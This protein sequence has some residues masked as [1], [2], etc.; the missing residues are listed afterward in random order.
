MAKNTQQPE[1]SMVDQVRIRREKLAQLQQEGRI[2]SHR[3][4]LNLPAT[5]PRSRKTSSRW[6]KGSL[7]Q[8]PPDDEARHG[9][10]HVL[11]SAGRCF[12]RIQLYLKIDEMDEATFER[13]RK[14]D[15][16]DIVGVHGDVFRTQRGEISVRAHEVVLLAKA[17]LPLPDKFHGLTNLE[18]RYRQRYVD[19]IVNPDVKDTFVKRSLILRELRSFLDGRGFLEVDTPI[20]PLFQDQVDFD[21]FSK[22]DF[23][24]VKVKEC[25]AVKKSKKLL[26]FVLDDGTG[27]DR[28]ILSGI[29]EY[30]EPEE[31]VGKTCIAITNLPPRA[32][33]G[34][35]SCG[36]LISAVHHEN[37]E[38]KAPRQFVDEI[39]KTLGLSVNNTKG[40]MDVC[41]G[42]SLNDSYWVVPADFDGKYADYNLYENRF[43]EALSLVAY[44]GVGGSREAFSTSP[45]LT[46][47]GMLRKAWRFVEGDGIYLY[48]GGTEG[49][50][51]AGREP[52]SEYYACQIADKMGIGCVQYDLENWKGILASK[53][54]LFTDIDTSFVPIGRILRKTTLKACLDYYKTLGDEFYE[55]L[56]SMLVFDA[57][58]Y[59]EDRH[60]GNFGLL[61]NNHTGEIIAPAPIFDNGL[62]LFNYAMPDDFKN[63]SAYAKT[64]SN[65][66]RISYEDVCKEVMGA[67]Q[68]A[69]LR[70][71][72]DFKFTRHPSL[73]LPE[74]RLTAIEKQLGERTREL[75]SIPVQRSAKRT[76]E[77]ER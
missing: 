19:L 2:P 73:N 34:I 71:M 59:N 62:S 9:Q 63:L 35:D 18:T 51:N 58:I 16:G 60:F 7:R 45:E 76:N 70:R 39:L 65:P 33:M 22:S 77:P 10:G 3:Q 53:C 68:K 6:R 37:G 1:L 14:L 49:V 67:K 72:V 61:R 43:S 50:P 40:I 55:Q 47:N 75:L 52:Y 4:S 66:Y 64:R 29:H 20:Q 28:V 15:I 42:L 54:R 23:R 38:E 27:T 25:E 48:K 11:R 30:Y 56:C 5:A 32:M 44:T 13:C 17:L 74:E 46:T 26:K 31:L 21:T 69:Q 36:M 24:A 12:G 8:R 57:L 41:M